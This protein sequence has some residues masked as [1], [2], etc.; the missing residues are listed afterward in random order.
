MPKIDTNALKTFLTSNNIIS[1]EDENSD[2]TKYESLLQLQI[3]K[4]AS[5]TGLELNPTAHTDVDFN[6]N[7]DSQDYNVRYYPIY[8]IHKVKVDNKCIRSKYYILDSDNGRLHFLKK[9]PKGEV[10]IVEYMSCE[11]YSFFNSKVLPLAYDMLLYSLDKSP[12]KNASSIKE[13]DLSVNYD[14]N[15]SLNA[16]IINRLNDLKNSRR[17]VVTRML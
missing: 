16:M 1:L 12:T 6:F 11:S 15:T 4:I 8:E 13:G 14:T 9:L 17:G 5:E 3:D 7:W 2:I 10:L